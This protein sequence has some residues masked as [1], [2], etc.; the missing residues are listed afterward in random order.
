VYQF[1]S[2]VASDIPFLTLRFSLILKCAIEELL[3]G[4]DLFD[5]RAMAY[6]V[7]GEGT[8]LATPAPTFS[9]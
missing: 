4:A 6:I 3:T 1:R 9:L 8:T 7:D 5:V 2:S